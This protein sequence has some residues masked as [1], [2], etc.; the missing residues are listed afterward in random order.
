MLCESVERRGEE[1]LLV[2]DD[3]DQLVDDDAG[4]HLLRALCLQAPRSCTS[5]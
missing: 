2:L 3:V 5:R 1:V 4:V